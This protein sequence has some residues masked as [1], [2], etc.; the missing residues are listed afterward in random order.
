MSSRK[1][2][3]PVGTAPLAGAATTSTGRVHPA[4]AAPA[5]PLPPPPWRARERS[6]TVEASADSAAIVGAVATLME[7]L[8]K[9][10]AERTRVSMMEAIAAAND[11]EPLPEYFDRAGIARQLSTSVTNIDRLCHEGLPYVRLGDMRRFRLADVRAWL[12][13]LPER[14]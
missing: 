7:A 6:V 4:S 10:V 13:S 12:E 1:T 9:E 8:L 11:P 3:S 5:K 14:P 2:P